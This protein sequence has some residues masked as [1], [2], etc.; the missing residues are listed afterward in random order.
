MEDNLA[1]EIARIEAE[2]EADRQQR[3]KQQQQQQQQQQHQMSMQNM[4]PSFGVSAVPQPMQ[5]QHQQSQQQSQQQMGVLHGQVSGSTSHAPGQP[6]HFSKDSDGRSIFVGNLPKG[7][8]GG[9]TTTPEE[10][11][12]L[13]ADCGPILNCTLLRDRTTGE[14]KGTA[15][16]EFSTYTGMGKA[17]DTKNNTMFKGSTLIVC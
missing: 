9:P 17:I 1:A 5:H 4:M 15:Y 3:E 2:L 8:N 6:H 10:L 11:A 16:V 13:F 12:H 14:L 7:D